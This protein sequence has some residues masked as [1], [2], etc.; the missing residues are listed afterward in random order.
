ME[1]E[2]Y[3]KSQKLLC[4]LGKSLEKRVCYIFGEMLFVFFLGFILQKTFLFAF[5][6]LLPP[7]ILFLEIA[8]D[9]K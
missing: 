4:K 2:K 7:S 9:R 1:Q 6:L 3:Q 5:H 8:L